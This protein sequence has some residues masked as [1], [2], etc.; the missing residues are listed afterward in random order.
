MSVHPR[1]D[2]KPGYYVRY[3]DPAGRQREAWGP[4]PGQTFRRRLDAENFEAAL[5]TDIK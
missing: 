5:K 4:A 3:R 1:R 2:G